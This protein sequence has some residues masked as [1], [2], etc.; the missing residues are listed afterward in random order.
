MNAGKELLYKRGWKI[1]NR[2]NEEKSASGTHQTE[3]GELSSYAHAGQS[4]KNTVY[5]LG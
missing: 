4:G 1:L 2:E 3:F 5:K